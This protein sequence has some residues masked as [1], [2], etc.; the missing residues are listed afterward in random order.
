MLDGARTQSR[1]R[2]SIKWIP[3]I[4]TDE[5]RPERKYVRVK[6]KCKLAERALSSSNEKLWSTLMPGRSAEKKRRRGKGKGATRPF[7]LCD[8]SQI[9]YGHK[10]WKERGSREKKKNGRKEETRDEPKVK[11]SILSRASR[12]CSEHGVL[13]FK[14]KSRSGKGKRSEK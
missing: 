5:K 9:E 14:E 12:S 2:A 10:G 6:P 7:R 3:E 8:V 13:E 11:V 1:A 4:F